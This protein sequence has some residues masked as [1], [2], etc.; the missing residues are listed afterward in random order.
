MPS[1]VQTLNNP[2][3]SGYTTIRGQFKTVISFSVILYFYC[4]VQHMSGKSHRSLKSNYIRPGQP[5]AAVCKQP[6]DRQNNLFHLLI[7]VN[8]R[9]H[10]SWCIVVLLQPNQMKNF[11]FMVH[12]LKMI[13]SIFIYGNIIHSS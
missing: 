12:F 13:Y 3:T 2:M 8:N 11:K 1:A 9:L 4:F 10:Q 5:T 7:C 6:P